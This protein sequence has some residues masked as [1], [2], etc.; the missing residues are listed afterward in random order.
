M[1]EH[2]K[3]KKKHFHRMIV[4]KNVQKKGTL[5]ADPQRYEDEK[6]MKTKYNLEHE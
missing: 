2:V 6:D 3:K 4:C 5:R 1:C